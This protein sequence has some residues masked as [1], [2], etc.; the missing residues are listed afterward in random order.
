M[1]LSLELSDN[2]VNE[3]IERSN[4]ALLICAVARDLLFP[5]EATIHVHNGSAVGM[6]WVFTPHVNTTAHS[7]CVNLMGMFDLYI[8]IYTQL[9]DNFMI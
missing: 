5:L 8:Y 3:E 2:T 9:T 6:S 4:R 1:E 7:K